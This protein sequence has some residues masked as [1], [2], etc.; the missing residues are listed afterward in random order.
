MRTTKHMAR[1]IRPRKAKRVASKT[2]ISK[3]Q[4]RASRKIS[5]RKNKR[6]ANKFGFSKRAGPAALP[7]SRC[8]FHYTSGEGLIGIL[9]S[10]SIHASHYGFLNDRSEG[11][12]LRE[13]LLP[14]LVSET[15]EFL[16]KLVDAGIIKAEL[17]A[18]HG[19][20]YYEAEVA[21]MFDSMASATDK[22][23]P[24]FIASFCMHEEG[25]DHHSDGLLSQ[26]RGY[27][28]GGFAV[29]FDEFELDAL[30]KQENDKCRLQGILT[31]EVR[32]R[33]FNKFVEPERFQ[34]SP[35]HYSKLFL[36]N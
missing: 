2:S 10:G 20:G 5:T 3:V 18:A 32:Y 4:K 19:D 33:D 26:W 13:I 34:D 15:R 17:L 24:Y 29:E 21:K 8:L 36:C 28:R 1:E 11:A 27:A 30:T 22:V 12:S 14:Y 16:P 25:T 9:Q 23:A 31:K 6:T 7:K 35:R